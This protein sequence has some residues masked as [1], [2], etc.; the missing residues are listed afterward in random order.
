MGSKIIF[1]KYCNKTLPVDMGSMSIQ[2]SLFLLCYRNKNFTL[3]EGE[4]SSRSKGWE[5]SK[6]KTFSWIMFIII[7]A[8]DA[9]V[10]GQQYISYIHKS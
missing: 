9:D 7:N 1:F 5:K 6:G 8:S 3:F 4:A 10:K 2:I